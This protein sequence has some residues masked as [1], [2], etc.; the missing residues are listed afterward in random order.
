MRIW[1]VCV[2]LALGAC[3]GK[4]SDD[5]TGPDEPAECCCTLGGDESKMMNADECLAAADGTCEPDVAICQ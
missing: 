5:K 4:K 1:I 2:V 3:G